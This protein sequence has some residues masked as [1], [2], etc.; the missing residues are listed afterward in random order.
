MPIE[1]RELIFKATIVQEGG[2]TGPAQ[3]SAGAGNNDSS[4]NE[5]LI[6]TCVEKV[7]EIIKEKDGR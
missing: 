5:E 2:G 4:P 6:K 7:M 3:N 1:I